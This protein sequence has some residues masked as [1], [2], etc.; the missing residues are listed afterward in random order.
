M[1]RYVYEESSDSDSRPGVNLRILPKI[2][3]YDLNTCIKWF[4]VI[5]I[6]LNKNLKKTDMRDINFSKLKHMYIS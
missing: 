6:G 3:I 2:F 4:E 1:R 5:P